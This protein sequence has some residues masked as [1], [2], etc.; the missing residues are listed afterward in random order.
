MGPVRQRTVF[1]A[2]AIA[3]SAASAGRG[4][5]DWSRNPTG[6]L[7]D[8][9]HEIPLVLAGPLLP[10]PRRDRTTTKHITMGNRTRHG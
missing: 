4:M 1:S 2:S 7:E 5:Q 8:E 10:R 3:A 6:L 9:R